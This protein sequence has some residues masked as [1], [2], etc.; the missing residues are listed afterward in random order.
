MVSVLWEQTKH[1][2]RLTR[3]LTWNCR[4]ATRSSPAW[5]YFRDLSPDVA[6]LQDVRS[7]PSSVENDFDVRYKSA[8]GKTGLPQKF[9]SAILVGGKIEHELTLRSAYDWVNREL[10][11]FVGNLLAYTVLLERGVH[12]NVVGVYN[13]AWYVDRARLTGIDTTPVRLPQQ[14]QDVWVA[15]YLWSALST[16]GLNPQERWVVAG[17]FNLSE[18]FDMRSGGPR[19]NKEYLDRMKKLGLTECLREVKGLLTPTFKNTGNGDVIHQ[20]DHLFVTTA[21]AS[22]LVAC[23]TGAPETVFARSLSDHLPIMADFTLAD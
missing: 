12:V 5:D 13:P 7:I 8:T 16:M 18:T 14:A 20:M 9:G 15:D 6:L 2:E 19:G 17:D 21:L 3:I 22:R 10:E 1:M 23:E 11:T 4:G